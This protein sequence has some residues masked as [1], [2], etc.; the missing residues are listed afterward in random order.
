MCQDP[1]VPAGHADN[2]VIEADTD[3]RDSA[4]D[5]SDGHSDFTSLTSSIL[6]YE[7]K[8]GRRYAAYKDSKYFL[9]NDEAECDRS[10]LIHHIYGMLLGGRL[11]LAPIPH[12]QR[13]VDLGCGTG[14]WAMDVADAYPSA[15]VLG[16]DISPIQPSWVPPN[17]RFVVDDVELPW[18]TSE[19]DKFDLVHF[20][21]LNAC[22]GDWPALLRQCFDNLRPGGWLEAK[23]TDTTSQSDDGSFP[24]TCALYVLQETIRDAMDKCGRTMHAP[25]RMKRWMEEAGFVDVTE[26]VFKLPFNPWPKDPEL[27]KIGRFQLAQFLDALKPYALGTL[28]ELLGWTS[29]EMEVALAGARKDLRNTKFH[30]YNT[31]RVV[32]GR[33]PGKDE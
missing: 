18:T 7:Y 27:K 1:A 8:N 33:K 17:V 32:T 14:I 26:Q 9:P 29:E 28:V 23:E 16:I 3:D 15:D 31:L 11:I 30:G 6:N 12:P 25:A 22:I 21:N 24:A 13:I 5:E 10:D 2:A 4:L 19:A 20:V